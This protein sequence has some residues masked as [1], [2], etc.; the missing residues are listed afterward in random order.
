[1]H[2]Q[3]LPRPRDAT[4]IDENWTLTE[5]RVRHLERTV[6]GRYLLSCHTVQGGAGGTPLGP[7][8]FPWKLHP[9]SEAWPPISTSNRG[10]TAI[11]KCPNIDSS[12]LTF[13]AIQFH[14][15]FMRVLLT[16]IKLVS[17]FSNL[18]GANA[19]QRPLVS[20]TG[21]FYWKQ[22][23]SHQKTIPTKEKNKTTLGPI[24]DSINIKSKNSSR[25]L[26]WLEYSNVNRC[27]CWFR[28][29]K[30]CQGI[31]CCNWG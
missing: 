13:P 29:V 30:C 21:P 11:A 9:S 14:N 6:L 15:K 28:A 25:C 19:E 5:R 3:S 27:G 8:R 2:T 23:P 16:K 10:E 20:T 12:S 7:G 17:F 4:S 18:P 26:K 24:V 22:V 31:C 1:M